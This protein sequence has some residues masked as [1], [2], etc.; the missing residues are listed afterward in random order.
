[1][2]RLGFAVLAMLLPAVAQAQDQEQ[3]QARQQRDFETLKQRVTDIAFDPDSYFG[4]QGQYFRIATIRYRGDDRGYP[5]YA[6]AISNGCVLAR[7]PGCDARR[8][9]RMVRGTMTSPPERPRWRGMALVSGLSKLGPL[10]G[11]GLARALDANVDWLEADLDSCS[12]ARA[13]LAK[14]GEARWIAPE[15]LASK[16]NDDL[17]IVLHADTIRV[18]FAGFLRS[19]VYDSYLAKDTP[20]A[21]A[22]GFAKAIEPC[23]KPSAA[24]RP[25]HAAPD[26]KPAPSGG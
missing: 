23:W 5:V 16:P 15:L 25:W 3:A 1:M 14:A 22:D 18:E 10:D 2:H 6:I 26:A 13:A 9:A 17:A 20:A 24:P 19:A 21:W 4:A 12:G 11:P 7:S 8:V